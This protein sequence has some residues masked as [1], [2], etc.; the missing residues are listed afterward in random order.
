MRGKV[1][2]ALVAVVI[3]G[4]AAVRPRVV[5]ANRD[6]HDGPGQGAT[7]DVAAGAG[8]AGRPVSI[9]MPG[10]GRGD[11]RPDRRRDE[12]LCGIRSRSPGVSR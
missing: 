8:H 3:A 7:E 1:S 9:G 12:F 5:E 2:A 10:S 11:R 6:I 4:A